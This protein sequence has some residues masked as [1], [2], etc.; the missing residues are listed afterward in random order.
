MDGSRYVFSNENGMEVLTAIATGVENSKKA[1]FSPTPV[2]RTS[3][4]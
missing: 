4:Q 3:K 1:L 2:G